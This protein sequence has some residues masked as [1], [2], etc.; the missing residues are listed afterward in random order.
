MSQTLH[1]LANPF[2][3]TD[4]KYR[5][6]PFNIAVGKFIRNMKQYDYNIIHYGHESSKVDCEHF[7]AVTNQELV[8]PREGDLL[9][10]DKR[11]SYI[12][13]QRVNNQLHK[14]KKPGDMILCFYGISHQAAVAEHADLKIIEPS[15]G[16]LLECVFAPY[17]GFTSYS[18]MHYYYG[19]H[20]QMLQPSWYDEVI[21]NAFTVEEFDFSA[22][23]ED[24]FV[25][26]GRITPDKGIDLA[27]QITHKIGK[28]LIVAGPGDLRQIGYKSIPSHVECI[29]YVN[30]D[31]RKQLLKN[32]TCLIAA[33]HYLE[34]FGNIVVE[35]M[36]SGTPVITTDWGGFVDTVQH[37]ITGYRCK[38][39]KT[40]VEA[41]NNIKNISPQACRDW[42]VANYSDQVVH[43]KFDNWLQK[44]R[45]MDFYRV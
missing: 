11:Y 12:F 8:P 9:L 43:Q 35:A 6:E 40:F 27:I 14:V 42:A 13:S 16:Y 32:A 25:Y 20:K 38:D 26:L 39:F 21:P 23:K 45:R 3:I 29:G 17:R 2:G 10:E 7:T 19:Y 44:I 41:A 37:G 1:V 4:P 15:I 36:L 31:Q 34:P 18:Q 24:Y 28:K 5:M 30:P 33:T 22:N